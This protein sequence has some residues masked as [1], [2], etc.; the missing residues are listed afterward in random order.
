[1]D[2][3]GPDQSRHVDDFG[4]KNHNFDDFDAK[5]ASFSPLEVE[6][7]LSFCISMQLEFAQKSLR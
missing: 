1:M 3:F 6:E 2:R 5:K 4:A 7:Y